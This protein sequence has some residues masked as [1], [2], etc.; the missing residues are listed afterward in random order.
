M[1]GWI[2]PDI[3]TSA[4]GGIPFG[5]SANRPTAATG[6]PYFNG[7]EKRLELYTST[8]W[9]N[10][11]SETPGIVSISPT[12]GSIGSVTLQIT[13]TNFT[14]GA[15]ASVIGSNDIE[16]QATSTTINSN[17]IEEKLS[18]STIDGINSSKRSLPLKFGKITEIDFFET[19]TTTKICIRCKCLTLSVRH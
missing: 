2:M 5:N 12:F 19:V 3:R 4:L 14:T 13:G 1:E 10:I 9:Q 18:A 15:I 11:I 17:S 7:E 6:Q 16:I 8:G